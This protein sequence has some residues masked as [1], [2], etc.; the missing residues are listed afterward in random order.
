MTGF[1]V[2]LLVMAALDLLGD[3]VHSQTTYFKRCGEFT[4]RE[5][6]REPAGDLRYKSV[7]FVQM[8]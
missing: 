2:I 7:I 5:R 4:E 1:Y 8:A 3:I 6:L